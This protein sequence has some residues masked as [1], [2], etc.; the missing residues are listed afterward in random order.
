MKV[1]TY[2][3][4]LELEAARELAREQG[5]SLSYIIR[6]GVRLLVGLSV[7]PWVRDE[8]AANNNG[9]AARVPPQGT[10]RATSSG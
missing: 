1:H 9:T 6:A 2:M 10:N 3:D 8:V 7:P 5:T 4:E